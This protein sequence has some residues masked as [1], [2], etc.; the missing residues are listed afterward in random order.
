MNKGK[1]RIFVNFIS[2][3]K[4]LKGYAMSQGNQ[5]F[6]LAAYLR[7]N[8]LNLLDYHLKTLMQGGGGGGGGVDIHWK[9]GWI[10]DK[11]S[12]FR[13]NPGDAILPEAVGLYLSKQHERGLIALME[14]RDTREEHTISTNELLRIVDFVLKNNFFEFN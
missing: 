2:F 1:P 3:Q 8:G 5:L 11:S 9:F 7:K 4:F 14:I 12:Q 6:Q 10:Y 13:L